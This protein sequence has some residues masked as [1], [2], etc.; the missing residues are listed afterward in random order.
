MVLS[1]T[2]VWKLEKGATEAGSAVPSTDGVALKST[3]IERNSISCEIPGDIHSA[4]I[5]AGRLP[6]PYYSMNEHEVQWVSE[7]NWILSRDF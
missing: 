7:N 6:D 5:A 2:G 4:L 3:H 1:L